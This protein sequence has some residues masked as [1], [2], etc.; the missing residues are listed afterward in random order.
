MEQI[1]RLANERRGLSGAG[2]IEA[3]ER[4]CQM[5]HHAEFQPHHKARIIGFDDDGESGA[6]DHLI[7]LSQ[8]NR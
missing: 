1:D 3:L 8:M 5:R 4:G 2:V 6:A 7:F